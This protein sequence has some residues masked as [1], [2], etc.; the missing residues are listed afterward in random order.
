MKPG[1]VKNVLPA[2][3]AAV[4]AAAVVAAVI[5]AA[6]VVETGV[7]AAAAAAIADFPPWS[8]Q[9]DFRVCFF[10]RTCLDSESPLDPG[11]S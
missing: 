4:I 7:A 1:P 10:R 5:A 11:F 6:V 3:A 9:A 2:A 8:A